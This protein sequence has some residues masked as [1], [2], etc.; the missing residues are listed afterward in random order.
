MKSI[1]LFRLGMALAS[2][3]ILLFVSG[4]AQGDAPVA[5]QASHGWVRV[6]K[7]FGTPSNSMISA[8]TVDPVTNYLYAGTANWVS[9]ASVWRYKTGGAWQKIAGPTVSGGAISTVNNPAITAM[10]MFQNNLYV[11]TAWSALPTGQWHYRVSR[12]NGTIWETVLESGYPVHGYTTFEIFQDNLYVGVVGGMLPGNTTPTTGAS[13]W[14]SA[15]GDANS[16]AA[17]PIVDVYNVNSFGITGLKTFTIAGTDALFAAVANKVDGVQVWKYDGTTWTT[18]INNGFGGGAS[19]WD[20]GGF[21]VYNNMLYL[22]V[23]NDVTGGKLYRT[24]DGAAWIPVTSNGFGRANNVKIEGTIAYEGSLY[25]LTYNI[26][27]LTGTVANGMEIWVS[28]DGINNWTP[29]KVGGF[30][31]I[32]NTNSLWTSAQTVYDGYLYIG[33]SNNQM[34]ANYQLNNGGELW[35]TANTLIYIPILRR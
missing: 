6:T 17:V 35:R 29:D 10:I 7:G 26:S 3:L 8:L 32:Y 27:P 31:S 13:I 12:W 4:L 1:R 20:S 28:V 5:T 24:S 11:G 21:T 18:V 9:G 33:T 19:S 14:M 30:H 25:A 15:S 22:G 34:D 23:R 2:L 16:W